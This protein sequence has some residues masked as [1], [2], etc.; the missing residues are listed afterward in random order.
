MPELRHPALRRIAARSC[1]REIW[2]G[3]PGWVRRQS[4]APSFTAQHPRDMRAW[5][6]N[7]AAH[8]RR[9]RDRSHARHLLGLLGPTQRTIP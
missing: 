6:L 1:T 2:K 8:C 9:L 4:L 7:R 3:A 5:V